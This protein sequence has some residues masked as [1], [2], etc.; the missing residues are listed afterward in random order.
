[1]RG[2]CWP[3]LGPQG[4]VGRYQ[5]RLLPLLDW[6]LLC[7]GQVLRIGMPE[8]VICRRPCL[9]YEACKGLLLVLRL[10][11]LR[12]SLVPYVLQS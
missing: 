9:T 3:W 5:R 8:G 4:D 11:F 10:G 6:G 12:K 1:M 7:K 2:Q